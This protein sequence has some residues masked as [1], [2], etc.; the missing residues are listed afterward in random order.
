MSSFIGEVGISWGRMGTGGNTLLM[1]ILSSKE[2]KFGEVEA[3]ILGKTSLAAPFCTT[4]SA[5]CLGNK[6]RV[7]SIES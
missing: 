4:K 7:F 2:M 6:G 5:S 3:V 1:P